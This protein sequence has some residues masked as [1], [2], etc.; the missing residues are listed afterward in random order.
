[1]RLRLAEMLTATGDAE[2]S[3]LLLADLLKHDA[4]DRDALRALG[5]L[6]ERAEKWDAASATYRRIQSEMRRQ[7]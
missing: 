6:E 3:G 4:K 5:R 7:R 2:Q 1:M